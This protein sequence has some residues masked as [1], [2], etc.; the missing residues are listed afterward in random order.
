[1]R[2]DVLIIGSGV[3]GATAALELAEDAERRITLITR[4]EE[5]TDSNSSFA[6]GGIVGRGSDDDVTLLVASPTTMKTTR[7]TLITTALLLAAVHTASANP[8]DVTESKLFTDPTWPDWISRT[9]IVFQVYQTPDP[10]SPT[11]TQSR[12]PVVENLSGPSAPN[13]SG[14]GCLPCPRPRR[15]PPRRSKP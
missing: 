7:R 15:S 1:M 11:L 14:C 5:A 12:P 3:A 10:C 6:Q 13:A 2:T 8:D 4:A 9:T